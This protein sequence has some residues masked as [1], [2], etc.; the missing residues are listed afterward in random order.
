[1][2]ASRI[3]SVLTVRVA[4]VQN[5]GTALNLEQFTA[6]FQLQSVLCVCVCV[7]VCV[8]EI[9]VQEGKVRG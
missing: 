3:D 4:R 6:K 5:L 7:C 2:R 8:C 1:M 9:G